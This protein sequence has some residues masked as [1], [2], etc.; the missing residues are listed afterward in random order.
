M[1]E[2]I[3][4]PGKLSVLGK[5][6]NYPL[7]QCDG[8]PKRDCH[9]CI[10]IFIGPSAFFIERSKPV[11]GIRSGFGLGVRTA[12]RRDE[13]LE[14]FD[15]GFSRLLQFVLFDP[16]L[17]IEP[18]EDRLF[19]LFIMQRDDRRN[20]I[21]VIPGPTLVCRSLLLHCLVSCD[22]RGAWRRQGRRMWLVRRDERARRG[23]RGRP[24]GARRAAVGRS[25]TRRRPNAGGSTPV[26]G[27]GRSTRV[28]RG[29]CPRCWLRRDA[30]RKRHQE[31]ACQQTDPARPGQ[32]LGS[33][34]RKRGLVGPPVVFSCSVEPAR[35][36]RPSLP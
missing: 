36:H 6:A 24:L 25:C 9:V 34:P 23:S 3:V 8:G 27:S 17:A 11:H 21:L 32:P 15:C 10:R 5:V 7:V 31:R 13:V 35:R 1:T 28:R 26:S 14:T 30:Q 20:R 29:G 33:T 19:L 4:D 18:P 2:K 16:D 22:L 12:V